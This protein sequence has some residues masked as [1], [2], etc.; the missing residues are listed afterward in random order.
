MRS[1]PVILAT[2]FTDK[3]GNILVHSNLPD[4]V[5]AGDHRLILDA[6]HP[7]GSAI[8]VVRH[9]SIGPRGNLMY[10]GDIAKLVGPNP[11]NGALAESSPPTMV[12]PA[13][14]S[15]TKPLIADTSVIPTPRAN[16]A[17][18][19]PHSQGAEE[20]F[21]VEIDKW[22]STSPT[23]RIAQGT[24]EGHRGSSRLVLEHVKPI[25]E[26]GAVFAS[27]ADCAIAASVATG[28]RTRSMTSPLVDAAGFAS[29]F[30]TTAF[31][32]FFA[33]RRRRSEENQEFPGFNS[34]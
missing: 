26:M 19:A 6:I 5:E 25:A 30:F 29:I 12:V 16:A 2:G 21:C 1:S 14:G 13:T 9:L 32:G 24:A 27:S 17:P 10:W 20:Q 8:Q 11:D 18:E 4:Q 23:A 7:D 3:Q 28:N 34:E 33:L 31:I 22:D 15:A